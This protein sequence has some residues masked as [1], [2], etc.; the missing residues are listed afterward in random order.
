[1]PTSTLAA[2][3]KINGLLD[4]KQP[5]FDNL[6]KICN[7]C[8]TYLTYDVHAG[9]WAVVINRAE[10][11]VAKAFTDANIIGP[12]Q[13]NGTGLTNLYNTVRVEYPLRDTADETDYVEITIPQID[14]YPNEPDNVL[15]LRL[16]MCNEPVQAE[17]IGLIELKQARLDTI[18]TFQSDYSTLSLNAGDIISVTN[19][20]YQFNAKKFRVITLREVDA[21]DGSVRIEVT[22]LAYD[23]N[24][25]D[26]SDLGRYIRSD[27]NGIKSIGAIGQPVAP[28]LYVYQNDARP[29]I[30]VEAVVPSG[31]VESM[32]LW[33]SS[34]NTN[35]LLVA[36]EYPDGGGTF[37]AGDTVLFDYDQI[38][39]QNVYVKVRGMNTTTTGPFSVSDSFMSFTPV[40][41]TDAINQDTKLFDGSGQL[42][43]A[44]GL[45]LILKKLSDIFTSGDSATSLVNALIAN[46][47]MDKSVIT[48]ASVSVINT[49]NS[50]NAMA[51]G[52]T[53]Q[54]G[55]DTATVIA[56]T[57]V[58]PFTTTSNY[59]VAEVTVTTPLCEFDYEYQDRTGNV[60]SQVGFVAQPAMGISLVLNGI[61]LIADASVD[62]NTNTTRFIVPNMVAGNYTINAYIV[63]TYDLDMNWVRTG[64]DPS[65]K[66]FFT[67]FNVIGATGLTVN[68]IGTR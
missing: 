13:V 64:V 36:T 44:L 21:D 9:K 24:V 42:L 26:I 14:R 48:T 57:I 60:N 20:L 3:Y 35:Y 32:E 1:M 53:T 11:T 8:A 49:E 50:L 38:P 58:L 7:A 33:L 28:V 16:D 54:D 63:P 25:Y 5:V 59:K 29:R 12:I 41:T 61:T 43:T 37:T 27:K 19:D 46:G 34:D 22:G 4:T 10:A 31:V 23:P 52:Y 18:I 30:E 67:N 6:E 56:N 68:V 40:Q 51:A 45:S 65:N 62:W 66:I 17:I 47:G 2:R 15:Q 39:A 55:Y